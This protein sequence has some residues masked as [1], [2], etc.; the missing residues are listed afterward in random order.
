M[1]GRIHSLIGIMQHQKIFIAVQEKR[2]QD[3]KRRLTES[4]HTIED[5]DDRTTMMSITREVFATV[6]LF[7]N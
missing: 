4:Y 1:K 5:E 7:S 2:I 3:L 6:Q